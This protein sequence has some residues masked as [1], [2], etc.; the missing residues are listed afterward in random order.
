[1]IF[2]ND[3]NKPGWFAVK[4]LGYYPGSSTRTSVSGGYACL[5][6]RNELVNWQFDRK[7]WVSQHIELFPNGQ[8]YVIYVTGPV[9][10]NPGFATISR[11]YW[12][13]EERWL[14]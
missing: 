3:P 4:S 1:M 5:E 12:V 13:N 7:V 6:A 14:K 11:I 10:D 2:S 9:L 8:C